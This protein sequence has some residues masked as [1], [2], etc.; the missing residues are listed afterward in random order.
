MNRN[1]LLIAGLF[2]LTLSASGC[3]TAGQGYSS[4]PFNQGYAQPVQQQQY[5]GGQGG[6]VVGQ[7]QQTF[8]QF[9]RNI[10][11]RVT[12]GLINRGINGLINAAF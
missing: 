5:I 8:G 3:R 4:Q 12:N 1:C 10:G 7:P 11:N 2:I 6:P 9:G